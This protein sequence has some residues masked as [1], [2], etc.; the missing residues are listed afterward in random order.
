MQKGVFG[1]QRGNAEISIAPDKRV[2]T[3]YI[4]YFSAE[5]YV[6]GTH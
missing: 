3:K 1:L 2:S 6:V 4:S 5:T